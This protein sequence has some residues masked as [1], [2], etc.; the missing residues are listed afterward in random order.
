VFLSDGNS[1]TIQ[2]TFHK[3]NRVEKLLPKNRPEVQN[4][5]FLDL[6]NHVFGR[7]SVRGVQKHDKKISKKINL[8]LVLFWP[9]THPPT[10]GVTDFFLLAAPCPEAGSRALYALFCLPLLV[11][12][13]IARMANGNIAGHIA[14]LL[15]NCPWS[16]PRT[17]GV[18]ATSDLRSAAGGSAPAARW[19]V[20]PA[21]AAKRMPSSK[22]PLPPLH[23]SPSLSPSL[24]PTP[25]PPAAR[26]R[27]WRLIRKLRCF[28]CA[29]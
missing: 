20:L 25:R 12:A 5:F 17:G 22:Q 11:I 9:L 23:P 29:V 24:P 8:T 1:K 21:S 4:R 3:K 27:L 28:F 19:R 6:F 18:G 16:A 7:L 26:H 2:K 15:L 13:A 10:T 14:C